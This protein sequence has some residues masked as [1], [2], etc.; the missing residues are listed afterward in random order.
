MRV[1][2]LHGRRD[3]KYKARIK[4]LVMDL[5][6]DAFRRQVEAEFAKIEA[7]EVLLP[8]E[9]L[10]RIAAYFKGPD[11]ER[12]SGD[13]AGLKR[14][15]EENA[16]FRAWHDTNVAAHRAP[17]YAIVNISLKPVGGIPGD[18]ASEQM[19]AVADLA[20][21]N[22][23]DE[24]RVSHEQNLVLP[25]VKKTDLYDVWR[26]LV[27]AELAAGNLGLISDIICCPG[28]DYCG[29]ATAR[30]IPIAQQISSH[31]GD[32][33][34][35]RQ[36]G[37]LKIKISGCINACGH[38]HAGHIGILGLEKRGA[39]YYQITLG[40]SG[41]ENASIGAILGPGFSNT[42]VVPAV[43]KIIDTYLGLREDGETFLEAYRRVG[44][45]P[46]KEALYATH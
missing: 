19:R 25:H 6:A 30:S 44:A 2:N 28:L 26:G 38:H 36:I 13:D 39:E 12:L 24:I 45:Q 35:Q 27:K 18:A 29:L 20:E 5:G 40:G 42:E 23:L 33:E 15:L 4:I 10:T 17:G 37:D 43:G 16:A 31:F 3:N 11:Y 22:S 1:Y 21:S 7:P 32:A 34:R 41:D 8:D 46:F 9:E 14:R